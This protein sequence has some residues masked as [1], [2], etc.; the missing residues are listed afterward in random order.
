MPSTNTEVRSFCNLA[1]FY[2]KFVK[3]YAHIAKPLTDL[4]GIP[5]KK[6]K[7]NL[8][9]EAKKSFELIKTLITQ[10]PILML[11]DVNKP[12][13]IRTDASDYAIGGVLFQRDE[14]GEEKPIS[15]ASRVLSKTEQRYST[16]EREMLAI[17]NW[18]R[19]WRSYIWGTS[20]KVYTDHSPLRG[21][22]TKKDVTRR[23]TRMI[24]NLQEYDF[25]LFYTPGKKNVVADALSREPFANF[26]NYA[27]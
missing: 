12:F 19:Y 7:I 17:Y 4:A 1:G 26:Q 5:G 15:F 10:E 3:G 25:Q 16:T 23:L 11:P 6:V 9:E 27:I 18:I 22:K 8:S 2:R 14:K 20:F 21:I 13:E 24:L